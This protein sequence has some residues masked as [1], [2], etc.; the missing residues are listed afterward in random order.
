MATETDRPGP[1]IL[2]LWGAPRSRSTAFARMMAERGDHT[3]VHEPFSHLLD[4]GEAEV[5]DRKVHS[6]AE[7]IAALRELAQD[8]PVFFKDTTDFHYPGLLADESFLREAA[9]TFIIRHPAEAITS[10]LALNPNLTRDEVGFSRLTEIFDAVRAAVGATP[11]VIDS[12]DLLAHPEETVRVYCGLVGIPFLPEAL[13]WESGMREEWQRTARWHASTSQT[14]GF[15]SRASDEAAAPEPGR[16]GGGSPKATAGSQDP[17]VAGF[18]EFHL[19]HYQ[20]LLAE[21]MV[22]TSP[23]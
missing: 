4:F 5:G 14:T 11:P 18:V 15:V 8:G 21:R 20:R 19:P 12:D 16:S 3:T 10:H 9:H 1:R 7:L 2:A 23:E 22:L 6:E 13:H 17:R